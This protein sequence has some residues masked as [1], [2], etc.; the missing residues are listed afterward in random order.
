M[1]ARRIGEKNPEAAAHAGA[2][3]ILI[4]VVF[5]AVIGAIG[6]LLAPQL[7]GLRSSA[8]EARSHA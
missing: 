5:G 4:G 2:Q 7:L 3:A 1:V 8:P 6:A